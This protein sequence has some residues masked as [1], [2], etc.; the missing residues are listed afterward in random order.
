MIEQQIEQSF[1]DKLTGL[2]YEYRSDIIDRKESGS[3]HDKKSALAG[4]R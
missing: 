1:I 2:K 3:D 4:R